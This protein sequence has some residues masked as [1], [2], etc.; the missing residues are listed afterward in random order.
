MLYLSANNAQNITKS[1]KK[2]IIRKFKDMLTED[3]LWN[4]KANKKE[5]TN[6]QSILDNLDT[7]LLI[8]IGSLKLIQLLWC[9]KKGDTTT[10][11]K[12]ITYQF[13]WT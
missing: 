5:N 1:S 6:L 12:S 9:I 11:A 7:Y 13:G 8:K 4:K 10:C 2:C 3:D